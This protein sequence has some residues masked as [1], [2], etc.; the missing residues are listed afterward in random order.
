[1]QELIKDGGPMEGHS[2]EAWR[3]FDVH[4]EGVEGDQLARELTGGYYV[5]KWSQA[6]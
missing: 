5:A 2:G 1:M 6:S 3:M 4:I